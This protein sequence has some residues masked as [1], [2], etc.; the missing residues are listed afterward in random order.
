MRLRWTRQA[1]EDLATIKEF[2]GRD[3][4][5][6]ALGIARHLY[7]ATETLVAF[8][9]SGRVVPERGQ[10]E[11]RELIRPPYRIIYRRGTDLVEVLTI[12]HSSRPLPGSIREGAV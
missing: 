11:I 3:S 9:E 7:H 10:P 6:Y 2:I 5:T 1:A 12:H 4:P 8:P